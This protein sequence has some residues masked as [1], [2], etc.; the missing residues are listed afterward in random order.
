[1][2][3]RR[4]LSS[5]RFVLIRSLFAAN[6]LPERFCPR[7]LQRS[8]AKTLIVTGLL[9]M[10][11]APSAQANVYWTD[12]ALNAI[13]SALIWGGQANPSFLTGVASDPKGIAV[14]ATYIYWAN[15]SNGTIGR[16]GL[17]GVYA[18]ENFISGAKA[19]IAVAVNGSYIYWTD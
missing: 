16:A 4:I 11:L 15:T 5:S 19:P 6:G 2:A 10:W 7:S 13:G 3:V 12:S 14:Y 18:N 9:V 8:L 1:M 17:D